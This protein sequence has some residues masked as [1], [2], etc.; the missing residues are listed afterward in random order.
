MNL[1]SKA[2]YS[3]SFIALSAVIKRT[4]LFVTKIILARLLA[5]SDFGL[6][7]IALLAVNTLALFQE[8]GLGATLIYKKDDPDFTN[9][10]TAF[11]IIPII[12]SFFFTVAYFSAPF[13]ADFFAIS[14]SVSVIRLLAFTLLI[15]SFGT[16]HSELLAKELKFR[17]IVLP[18]IVPKVIY[19]TMTISLAL[20][21][22]GAW[23]L[24]YGE[25]TTALTSV[26][27]LW[28]VSDWRPTFK[29]NRKAA[30]ELFKYGKYV[31]ITTVLW[32][33]LTNVDNAIVGKMLGT[34]MLGIYSI[35]YAVSTLPAY[36][37]ALMIDRVMFP[38]YSK[39]Q[40]DQ[41]TLKGAYLKTIKY[42]SIVSIP[43]AFGIFAIAPDFVSVVLGDKWIAAILPI[44]VLSIYGLTTSI[45]TSNSS[46][47][48]SLGRP[49]IDSKL[50]LLQL[51]IFIL[52]FYPL[53][54]SLGIVGISLAVLISAL[55]SQIVSYTVI[56]YVF[57][58]KIV[59]VLKSIYVSLINALLMLVVLLFAQTLISD[60][61]PF[62][63]LMISITVGILVYTSFC[64]ITSKDM[65]K[66]LFLIVNTRKKI[67]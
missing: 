60:T 25:I 37:I 33:I 41:S 32:F 28:M 35:S 30:H 12:A 24:V 52:I 66:E 53:T 58:I 15:N 1:K 42:V 67:S 13:I 11:I 26:I 50:E 57:N 45:A 55:I 2:A 47:M 14:S 65:F 49:D 9:A 7:A 22:F 59:D 17:K 48:K 36:Q 43:T 29:F 64:Y 63:R 62:I 31:L 3:F 21:G 51:I 39:L 54:V 5:P 34:E 16:V 18:E 10:N 8:F 56:H 4:V 40:D 19:A 44:Q 6:V 46:L 38:I 20:V 27:L 23:S 61:S